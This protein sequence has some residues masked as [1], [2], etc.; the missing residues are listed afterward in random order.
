MAETTRPGINDDISS[1][2]GHIIAADQVQGT[3][4]YNTAGR[5]IGTVDH[6]MI[7]K[8]SGNVRYVVMSFGGFLGIGRHHHLLPWQKL[9]YDTDKAGYVVDVDEKQLA[10]APRHPADNFSWTQDYGRRVD[11]YYGVPTHWT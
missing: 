6:V 11:E 5:K 1:T 3:E 4:V 7:D 2:S 8:V 9:R 10:D